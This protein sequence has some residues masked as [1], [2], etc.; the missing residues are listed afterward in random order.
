MDK[1]KGE[2]KRTFILIM[3]AFF[4]VTAIILGKYFFEGAVYL[5]MLIVGIIFLISFKQ[6]L[7]FFG[8]KVK[9]SDKLYGVSDNPIR[10]VF[11][12]LAFGGVFLILTSIK[13]FNVAISMTLPS[14]PL[15][16]LGNGIIVSVVAPICEEIFFTMVLFSVLGLFLP[17]LWSAIIKGAVFSAFHIGAYLVGSEPSA[18]VGAFV[19]AGVF[20]VMGCYLAKY[21]GLES[22]ITGHAIFNLINFN[23]V[24]HI[25]SVIG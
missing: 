21:G 18:M 8:V 3:I 25:F 9:P 16:L 11:I 13:I 6:V 1:L 5:T 24:Y 7:G 12:G 20:G 19:G 2:Q 22:T 17:T 15:S 10:G 23:K 14:L 4:I